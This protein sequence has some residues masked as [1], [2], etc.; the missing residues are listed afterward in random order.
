MVKYQSRILLNF[1]S[2]EIYFPH[3]TAARVT[4]LN[5]TFEFAYNDCGKS[6]ALNAI[7]RQFAPYLYPFVIEY[8]ILVVGIWFKICANINQCPRKIPN[9]DANDIDALPNSND[10][11]TDDGKSLRSNIDFVEHFVGSLTDSSSIIY[12]SEHNDPASEHDKDIESSYYLYA[13]CRSSLRGIFIGLLFVIM[14]I[15]FIIL[16]YVGFENR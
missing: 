12:L 13:D 7:H 6:N 2:T 8:C 16:M 3:S 11:S 10:K 15:V 4:E 9:T 1:L 14:T 5:E